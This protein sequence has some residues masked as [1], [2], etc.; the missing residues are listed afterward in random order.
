MR[1]L[2]AGGSGFIG[3]NLVAKLADHDIEYEIA[4][5]KHGVDICSVDGRDYEVIVLLAANLN[6]DMKMFQDNLAIYRWAC[7]QTAH[8]IYTSSAAVYADS[9]VP[10]R[11]SDPT[12]APTIYGYSKL[13]GELLIRTALENYTILRLANVYGNGDG[14]GAI[15]IFKR[16]G[17]KIYGDGLDIRDYVS[18]R[19]VC[20]A[21][22]NIALDPSR[23]NK[24]TFNISGNMPMTTRAAY[25]SFGNWRKE[26]VFYPA[27]GY[28][29]RH[30]V[31]H[32]A[33]AIK[34]GLIDE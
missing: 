7:K 13:L 19:V 28:D 10:H 34:A 29:V 33:K 3:K 1:I 16:G 30:S 5:L 11:E 32:N 23:Y 22:K 14:N 6:H 2:V 4:D 8:I 25:A 26:P 27:R 31:L 17:N 15:D 21:I 18:V 24:E 20:D 12:P 9:I